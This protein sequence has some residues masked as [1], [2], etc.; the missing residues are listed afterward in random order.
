MSLKFACYKNPSIEVLKSLLSCTKT[1]FLRL[2]PSLIF[3]EESILFKSFTKHNIL[4]LL[5]QLYLL[6]IYCCHH[7]ILLFCCIFCIIS[8]IICWKIRIIWKIILINFQRDNIKYLRYAFEVQR[9]F[10]IHF[11]VVYINLSSNKS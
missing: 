4:L 11:Y 8:T 1:Y 7:Y 6:L 2:A 3:C 10:K 5:W 9:L